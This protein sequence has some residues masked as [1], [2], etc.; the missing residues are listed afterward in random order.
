[1]TS[2]RQP[3][4]VGSIFGHYRLDRLIGRGGMGEVYEAYDLRKRR[5]VAIK[6]L[7]EGLAQDE[8]YRERFQR[9]ADAAA[10]LREPHVIPIHDYGEVDGR[11]YIDMRLVDGASLPSVLRSKGPMPA[12]QA[13]AVI[14]QI[15][16]ALDAAHAEGLVHRDVKPDNILLTP[17]GFAYLVDFGIAHSEADHAL[18]T[19]GAVI[20]SFSYMAPERFR[21][22]HTTPAVD[23]YSLA[24]VLY[25]CLTGARPYRGSTDAEIISA[26]LFEP[27]PRPSTTRPNVTSALD[28]VIERGMA[29][30]VRERYRA[31]GDLAH[32]A[33]AALTS[34]G[35]VTEGHT[36][37]SATDERT[38]KDEAG[39]IGSL[40]TATRDDLSSLAS[41]PDTERSDD[42]QPDARQPRRRGRMLTALV[43]ALA[44]VIAA[45][46]GFGAWTLLADRKGTAVADGTALRDADIDLLKIVAQ[47]GRKR[48]TCQHEQPDTSTTVAVI[49]CPDHPA[50]SE[51]AVRYMRFRNL[52][53]L[54]DYYSL[55]IRTFQA[56][57]CPGDPAGVDGPVIYEG[58]E[59]GR[60]ACVA[61]RAESPDA[62]KPSLVVTDEAQLALAFFIWSS[63]SDE[64]KRDYLAKFSG[65]Q[66]LTNDAARDPDYFTPEDRALLGRLGND[67][68]SGNCRHVPPPGGTVNAAIACS[69]PP[70]YPAALFFGFPDSQ[71]ATALYR[72]DVGVLGGHRCG[73]GGSDE[74]W[75]KG[76]EQVGRFFCFLDNDP[77]IGTR[78]CLIAVHDTAHL[79]SQFCTLVPENPLPGPKTEAELLNW[80]DKHAR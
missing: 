36:A 33:E 45:G 60:K 53:A 79:I 4:T 65:S 25:E 32:A 23:V 43:L 73:G 5:S 28:T 37:V 41:K 8:G 7:L 29:K 19:H 12:P 31:A 18:T 68:G 13:V 47:T 39:Q 74:V 58:K 69:T 67:F 34:A 17:D 51:S 24:C 49:F 48:S 30:D 62:P 27:V 55:L 44:A 11:L 40:D 78:T 64:A 66:F 59:I 71:S 56:T 2:Q 72:A 54:R 38:S 77:D 15:A 14:R 50:A 42:E 1:M 61:N 52:D 9:E 80:F 46:A 57:N 16:S 63:P 70:D 3:L 75:Q 10:R 26:H 6:V 20:G 21:A 22:E 35:A 76:N